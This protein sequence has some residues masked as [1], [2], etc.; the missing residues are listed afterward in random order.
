MKLFGLQM[1]N[2]QRINLS[3]FNMQRVNIQPV[4]L[5]LVSTVLITLTV[6][7]C[8]LFGGDKRPVYQGAEYYK[9]LEVPPDLTE[10]D[11]SNELK[12]PKPTDEA[13]QR[14]RDNNKLEA[15]LTPK[16]DGVRIVSYAGDSWIEID[17]N[18]EEVWSELIKFWE[19]EGIELVQQRPLL[20]FMETDWTARLGGKSGFFRSMFQRFEPDQKDKF[21]V[22]LERFDNDRKTRLYLAH[23]RIERVVRGEYLDEYIWVSLPSDIEAEREI[24]S[25]MALY[26]GLSKDQ[27]VALLENYRPYSSL[28]KIERTNSTALTMA[29]S[30]DFV[31]RRAMRALD[32]MRMQDIREEQANNTIHFVVGKVSA[33]QLHVEEDELS[34]SSWLMQLFTNTDETSLATNKN[35]QYRLEFSE[36]NGRIQIEVIDAKNTRTTDDD[37]NVHGTALAEQLRNLLAEKLE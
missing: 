12:V 6:S 7:S 24:I 36:A 22:R 29:G 34:K 28:V 20:G 30:M 21:R 11:T 23:T 33:E 8:G 10:P 14:F 26:V 19:V 16:F 37:G 1:F 2:L 25:R 5:K 32:R 17:N 35:R 4:S 13:L 3:M 15:V 18:A 9:N 27:S 31:W